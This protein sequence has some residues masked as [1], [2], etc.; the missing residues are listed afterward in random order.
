MS[1]RGWHRPKPQPI[2]AQKAIFT[3]KSALQVPSRAYGEAEAS[4]LTT[5]SSEAPSLL[6]TDEIEHTHHWPSASVFILGLT[7]PCY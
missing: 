5:Q 1:V 4:N 3:Q 6:C 7:E 2:F